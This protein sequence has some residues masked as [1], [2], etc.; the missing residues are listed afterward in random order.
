MDRT[1]ERTQRPAPHGRKQ[2][3][4]RDM[5]MSHRCWAADIKNGQNKG[6]NTEAS[7]PREEIA[8]TARYSHAKRHVAKTWAAAQVA[9]HVE[10][11]VRKPVEPT[12]AR[13]ELYA[14]GGSHQT[15]C[16]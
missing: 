8:Q 11:F 2:P 5:A 1:K 13:H 4:R 12:G 9:M 7:T 3:K 15:C 16:G 10:A 14:H 6:D